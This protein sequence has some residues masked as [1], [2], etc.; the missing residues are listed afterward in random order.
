MAMTQMLIL[1]E[2]SSGYDTIDHCLL[3]QCLL[4]AELENI[5]LSHGISATM[6]SC[7][8]YMCTLYADSTQLYITTHKQQHD[9]GTIDHEAC[10]KDI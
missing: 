8:L 2:F 4:V 10:L 5:L 9:G 3:L 1:L 6:T 7:T